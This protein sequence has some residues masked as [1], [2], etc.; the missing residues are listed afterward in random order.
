MQA[1]S[2]WGTLTGN[3][4][5][6]LITDYVC[7]QRKAAGSL[8]P[9][10]YVVKTL[11]TTEMIRRIAQSYGVR[12]EGDLQVGFKYIGGTMDQQ[13]PEKFVFGA[14]ESYGFLAGHYARDKDAAV[15]AMLLSELAARCKA[16]GQ[17]L[18][19]KLDSLFWQFGCHAERQVSQT[20]PGSEGMRLMEQLMERLRLSPPS[21]LADMRV[22]RV[23]DYKNL[24]EWRTGGLH[25]AF[26]GPR[27]DMVMIDLD[28]EGTYVAV[29]PSGTEPK[30]KF[31]MFTYEPAEQLHNLEDTKQ[32]LQ[33]RLDALAA[34]LKEYALASAG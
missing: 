29:R 25:Q 17:T 7:E 13:G 22:V 19:E 16:N 8:S 31:Y 20:M 15:A 30:V 2:P 18:H 23:R 14:E 3:Q 6:A 5:G 11:V 27:G 33:A 34:S 12:T 28:R 26:D 21:T 4:I 24:M 10:H 1:G 32:E 9:Q